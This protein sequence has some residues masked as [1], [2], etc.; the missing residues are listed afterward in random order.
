MFRPMLTS[1][2][3]VFNH[4][5]RSRSREQASERLD[6]TSGHR[7]KSLRLTA[8][9]Q[10]QWIIRYTY[11]QSDSEGIESHLSVRWRQLR[12]VLNGSRFIQR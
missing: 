6:D 5:L 12:G 9:R 7:R 2:C 11:N 8:Q 4:F 1:F 3:F 10:N